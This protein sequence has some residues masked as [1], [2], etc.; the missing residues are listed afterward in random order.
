MRAARRGQVLTA[1]LKS[2]PCDLIIF[3]CDGVLVDSERL[4]CETYAAIFTRAGYPLTSA[5]VQ[6]RFLGRSLQSTLTSIETEFGRPLP[7]DF[8]ATLEAAVRQAFSTAL[9]PIP[10]IAELLQALPTSA[11]VASSGSPERIRTSLKLTSLIDHFEPHIFSAHQ[12]SAGKPAPDLFLF[13]AAQMGVAPE[14]CLVIEDSVAGVTAARHANIPVIGFTGGSH[15]H[16]GTAGSLVAAGAKAVAM[17]AS[18][19][20]ALLGGHPP[21]LATN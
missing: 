19:L 9:Q 5:D 18:S 21:T 20:A 16:D 7:V 10:G 17:D 12:V 1:S 3:D 6:A 4:A 2:A 15:C 14:R 8:A 11:C 13:A